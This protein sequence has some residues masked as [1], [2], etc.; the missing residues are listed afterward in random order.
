MKKYT[1][2]RSQN[3]DIVIADESVGRIHAEITFMEDGKLFLQD[4]KSLNGTALLS[5]DKYKRINQEYITPQDK[6]SF[7][8]FKIT[9]KE[10]LEYISL[11][12]SEDNDSESS[13]QGNGYKPP[14]SK[15]LIRCQICGSIKSTT[16]KC[17]VC[18]Q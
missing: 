16:K 8:R 7:G 18:H 11:K 14:D 6:V 17:P 13:I 10:L 15:Q 3:C 4:C 12:D 5:S 9:V 2:G 1:I